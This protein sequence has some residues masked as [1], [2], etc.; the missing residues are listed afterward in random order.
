MI[1]GISTPELPPNCFG[2][3]IYT[4]DLIKALQKKGIELYVLGDIGKHKLRGYAT[5]K[6]SNV[7]RKWI[8]FM[9]RYWMG[10]RELEKRADVYHNNV[11]FMPRAKIPSLTV[12]H[13]FTSQHVSRFKFLTRAEVSLIKRYDKIVAVSPT[14]E[15][16]LVEHKVPKEKLV[17]IPP[18]IWTEDFKDLKKE[19]FVMYSGRFCM[20]KN[21]GTL[22]EASNGFKAKLVMTGGGGAFDRDYH[23]EKYRNVDCKGYVKKEIHRK[24]LGSAKVF[25]LPS[26]YETFGISALE[27]M[28][29]GSAVVLSKNAGI[30]EYLEHGKHALIIEPTEE[31]IVKAV[32]TLLEDDRLRKKLSRNGKRKAQEFHWKNI[33]DKYIE[34]YREML[35]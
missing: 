6:S 3:G 32:N 9:V 13:T 30:S 27:A 22:L 10:L 24:L 15:K 35:H 14:I 34:I 17:T 1:V 18:G 19:D 26:R 7:R 28:A 21:T 11:H 16:L 29:S 23:I 8:D 25:V 2:I 20:D 31:N 4:S 12:T 5:T 33:V